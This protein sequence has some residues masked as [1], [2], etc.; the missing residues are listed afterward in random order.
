MMKLEKYNL[1]ELL[2]IGIK[3]ETEAARVYN[4][5]AAKVKNPF[6]KNR[7]AALSKEELAH[8]EILEGLYRKLYPGKNIVVPENPEFLPEFPEIKI[9]HELGTTSDIR[10]V[11]GESMKAELSAKEYYESI[12]NMV[13]DEYMKKMMLYMAKIEEGHYMIL[14]KEYDDMVEFEGMMQ[15]MD[16]AQFDAR[17]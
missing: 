5:T 8:K 14:K 7:L 1:E 17:F 10:T 15:D 6:L 2:L 12:A 9:F 16:Y 4:E 13:D 3:S 11:L